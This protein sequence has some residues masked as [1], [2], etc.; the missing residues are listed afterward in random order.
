M[1]LAEGLQHA[2]EAGIVHRDIKP[3]NIKITPDGNIK[4]L[5]FGLALSG[6][7]KSYKRGARVGT[8]PYMSP[9]QTRGEEVDRRSDIWSFGIVMYEVFRQRT[10]DQRL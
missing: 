7:L 4:I 1:Q 9:E 5:D 2:H 3:V 10:G 6:G 8:L